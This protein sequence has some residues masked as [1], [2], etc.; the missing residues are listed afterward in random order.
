MLQKR[1]ATVNSRKSPVY[2]I[3]KEAQRFL[4]I[5]KE[6]PTPSGTGLADELLVFL[7]RLKDDYRVVLSKSTRFQ[8]TQFHFLGDF[9]YQLESNPDG[10]LENGE[11]QKLL[12]DLLTDLATG[13]LNMTKR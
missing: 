6:N 5:L 8:G 11:N 12:I 1:S 2:E 9:L 4:T 7:Y 10:T 13:R 3:A